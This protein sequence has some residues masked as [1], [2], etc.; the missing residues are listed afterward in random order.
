[1]IFVHHKLPHPNPE[2]ADKYSYQATLT[3]EVKP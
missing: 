3:F 2:L 1:M